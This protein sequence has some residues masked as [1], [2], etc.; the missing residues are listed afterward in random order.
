[1][2]KKTCPTCQEQATVLITNIQNGQQFCHRCASTACPTFM[3]G[4]VYTLEDVKLLRDSGIDPEVW[5]I[6]DHLRTHCKRP[7]GTERAWFRTREE[8]QVFAAD[9][10]N[11]AYHGDIPALCAKCDFYHLNRPE[12]LDPQLTHQDAAL[13]ESM[14]IAGPEKMPGDLRCANCGVAFRAGIDFFI[15]PSGEMICE[16]NCEAAE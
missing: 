2:D 10:E 4:L 15:L 14:A 12:W 9:P 5:E 11:P 8:A 16:T 7:S 1:M 3:P 6:E 13:L